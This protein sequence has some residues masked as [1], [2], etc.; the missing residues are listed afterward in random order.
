[1]FLSFLSYLV[2]LVYVVGGD[3]VAFPLDESLMGGDVSFL[4]G[5]PM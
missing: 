4:Y 1:M 5:A 3:K 2:L